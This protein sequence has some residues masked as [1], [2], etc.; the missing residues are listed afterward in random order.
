MEG[1][2]AYNYGGHPAPYGASPTQPYK[3]SQYFKV[4]VK[5]AHAAVGAE[6]FG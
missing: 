2:K 4:K 5:S 6:D 1:H 3:C